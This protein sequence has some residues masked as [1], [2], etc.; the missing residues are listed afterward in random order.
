MSRQSSCYAIIPAAGRSERMNRSK[1]LLSW[2]GIGDAIST[3]LDHVLQ[4]WTSSGVHRTIVV[5]RADAESA[6]KR[7][8]D[9]HRVDTV[10]AD[11]PV[12]MKASCLLGLKHLSLHYSPTPHD[13]FFVCPA[14]IPGITTGLIDRLISEAERHDAMR[15]PDPGDRVILPTYQARRGHPVL[16]PWSMAGELALLSSDQGVNALVDRAAV[17]EVEFSASPEKMADIDTPEE[18]AAAARL[19][20]KSIQ[21]MPS[22]SSNSDLPNRSDP[23]QALSGD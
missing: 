21:A 3:L 19:F 16:F 13:R 10:M 23:P 11:D 7:I 4:A 17:V 1:L 2:P 18:Y 15:D 6:V 14:D 20:A 5:I 9:A 12:D 22:R 8:C